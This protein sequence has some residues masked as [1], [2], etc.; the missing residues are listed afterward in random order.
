MYV[1]VLKLLERQ[2]TKMS[3][4]HSILKKARTVAQIVR[5][6]DWRLRRSQ[7]LYLTTDGQYWNENNIQV[8]G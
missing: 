7:V 8:L 1:L 3:V 6:Y 5:Y 4:Y 2:S